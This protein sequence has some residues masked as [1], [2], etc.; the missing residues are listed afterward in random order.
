MIPMRKI[1]LVILFLC[2][3]I[4]VSAQTTN[5]NP[6][7][8]SHGH[9]YATQ[10]T[11]AT[12]ATHTMPT[13]N[14]KLLVTGTTTPIIVPSITFHT[15]SVGV[16]AVCFVAVIDSGTTQAIGIG[17]VQPSTT[18]ITTTATGTDVTWTPPDRFIVIGNGDKLYVGATVIPSLSNWIAWFNEM[19]YY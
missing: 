12:T 15:D 13:T 11:A 14:L 1:N 4:F 3:R 9:L 2:L 19:L 17:W 18:T 10:I 16:S 6:S 8:A 5:T 7:A